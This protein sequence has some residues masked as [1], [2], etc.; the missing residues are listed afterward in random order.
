MAEEV[1]RLEKVCKAYNVGLPSETEVL[2]DIDLRLE[3]GEF[4]ALIGPSGSGK[5]TLLKLSACSIADGRGDVHQGP[6]NGWLEDS[7]ITGCAVTGLALFQDHLPTW[8]SPALEN[9]LMPILADRGFRGPA[10]PSGR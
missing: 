7:A 9:V 5:S 8:V 4:L 10:M 6:G 3:Q 1:L 2:H